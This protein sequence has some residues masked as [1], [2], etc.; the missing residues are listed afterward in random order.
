VAVLGLLVMP[1]AFA[2]AKS[3]EAQTSASARAQIKSLKKRVTALE[4]RQSPASLPP[5][6]PAGGDLIGS[7]PNPRLAQGSVSDEQILD[8]SVQG[9]DIFDRSIHGID[10]AEGSIGGAEIVDGG[11]GQVDLHAQSVGA[12]QLKATYERVSGGTNLRANVVGG[13]TASCNPG[14]KILGG[15]YAWLLDRNQQGT[16]AEI[17]MVSTTPNVSGAGFDNPDQ[18]AVGGSSSIPNELFAWAVCI[19]A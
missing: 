8:G 12:G 13:A 14:D 10:L 11:I 2:G 9:Q 1:I 16:L 18:W 15:G 17:H 4:T 6:G 5:N 19:R 3:P 7:Y